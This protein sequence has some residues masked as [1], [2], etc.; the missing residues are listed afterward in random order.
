MT[1]SLDAESLFRRLMD[2]DSQN[3]DL[4][5]GARGE[6]ELAEEVAAYLDQA[7]L[8]VE[9]HDVVGNRPNV[10]ATLPGTVD[11]PAVVLEA[12]LDT[13]PDPAAGLPARAEGR[14]FYGRGACDT[15]ASLASMMVAAATLARSDGARPPVVVAGVMDEEYVMRGA[16]ALVD[17]LPAVQGIVI[18][19]PT[20]LLPVRAHNGFIRVEL[21]VGGV[22][23]HSSK[24]HLGTNAIVHASR[25]VT[26]LDDRLGEHLRRH[27]HAV[28]GPALLSPTMIGGGIAPN[29]VPDR[30]RVMFD[31]RLAPGESVDRALGQIEE[32]LVDLRAEG[33]DVRLDDPLVAL[34][35]VSTETTEPLVLA[36]GR[37]S[38]AVTGNRSEPSG[39]TYSTDACYLNGVGKHP[40]VVLG[41]GSIDQAHTDDEW[42]DLD[43]VVRAVDV[44]VAIVR[45]LA[46][47]TGESD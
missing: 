5:A 17:Q 4:A 23:A 35:A 3:P 30:C 13:V 28:T 8:T 12:H 32:V 44:Y 40:C 22:T 33:I 26:A 11:Q 21:L 46:G 25:V 34:P 39:V 36:A 24:A 38:A 42:V 20:S 18:G 43:E 27:P 31:R 14:R 1:V 6:R 45:D 7:G 16:A 37:A 47:A 10:V 41:P 19:E 15:K 2:I 29:I 9:L